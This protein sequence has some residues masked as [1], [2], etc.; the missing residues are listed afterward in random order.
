MATKNTVA[1][2]KQAPQAG[3]QWDFKYG[4][5]GGVAARQVYPPAQVLEVNDGW[6]RYA[7]GKTH[8][9]LKKSIATFTHMY[10]RLD[11]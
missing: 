8:P 1:T 11:V 9:D 6:V 3:E 7:L 10:Y 4:R 2:A 5:K